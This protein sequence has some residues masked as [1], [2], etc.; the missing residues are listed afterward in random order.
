MEKK[1]EKRGE[2]NEKFY[3][4]AGKFVCTKNESDL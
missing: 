4:L 1:K 2:K 3:E